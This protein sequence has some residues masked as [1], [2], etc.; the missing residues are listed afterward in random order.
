MSIH[1]TL[2]AIPVRFSIWYM[3]LFLFSLVGYAMPKR[4]FN[5]RRW[6]PSFL[7]PPI[8]AAL[9]TVQ[10][11]ILI[12]IL[13]FW[14]IFYGIYLVIKWFIPWP[15]KKPL[16][17]IPPI[18]QFRQAGLFDMFDR[19]I[20]VIPK[21]KSVVWKLQEIGI[22]IVVFVQRAASDL[23]ASF[24]IKSPNHKEIDIEDGEKKEAKEAEKRYKKFMK[25]RGMDDHSDFF[26]KY[27]Q[28]V[29]EKIR[30]D[31]RPEQNAQALEACRAQA[32]ANIMSTLAM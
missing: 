5:L 27:F 2:I 30:P 25:R 4:I 3:L 10:H 11:Y 26:D 6:R 1:E 13:V 18:K 15:I 20:E 31:F 32:A 21:R 23:L 17:R 9:R 12:A 19:I 14:A 22:A 24:G 8:W 16:L 29:E 7:V 28:C